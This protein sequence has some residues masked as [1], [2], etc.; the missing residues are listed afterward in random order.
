MLPYVH[1]ITKY[2]P[3]DHGRYTGDQE[4]VSDHGPIEAAYLQALA[5]FAEDTDVRE[6]TIRGRRSPVS[7]A[8][9]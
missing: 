8:S 3:A 2:D 7:P 9:V 5:A 1:R 4:P 6:L